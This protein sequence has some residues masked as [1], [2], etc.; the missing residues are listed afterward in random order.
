MNN[1][2]TFNTG[3]YYGPDGQVIIAEE[4]N[5]P[6]NYFADDCEQYV[7][8]DDTTRGIKGRIIL[9][10]LKESSIMRAYDAGNYTDEC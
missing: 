1:K 3:R 8:F 7:I 10:E 4:F 2:I 6:L 5:G 9:C